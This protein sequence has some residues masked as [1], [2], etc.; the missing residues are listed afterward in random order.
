MM[1]PTE[2][3]GTEITR[4][5]NELLSGILPLLE[6]GRHFVARSVNAILITT[7]GL[8]GQRLVEQ[9]Q[10]GKQRAAYDSEL[11][12]EALPGSTI[13]LVHMSGSEF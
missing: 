2:R 10:S 1:K 6:Q 7:Y 9:E 12:E 5:Y 4:D 11:S 13:P 8:V 3:T